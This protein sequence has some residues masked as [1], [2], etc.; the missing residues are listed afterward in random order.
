MHR[1]HDSRG[2]GL[3]QG[4]AP[5]S[6]DMP[7][8]Y[9]LAA[10]AAAAPRRGRRGGAILVRGRG[11]HFMRT[12]FKPASRSLVII[13]TLLVLGPMVQMMEHCHITQQPRAGS[14][15]ELA[16]SSAALRA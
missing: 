16:R 13:S 12:M 6:R 3:D 10:H 9:G 2:E 8:G 15:A 1:A 14:A 11:A 7:C 4:T 5:G